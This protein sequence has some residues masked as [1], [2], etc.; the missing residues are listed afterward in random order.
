MQFNTE[1]L[2]LVILCHVADRRFFY[3][4]EALFMESGCGFVIYLI[5]AEI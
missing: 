2:L 4:R 1:E 5:G 3:I